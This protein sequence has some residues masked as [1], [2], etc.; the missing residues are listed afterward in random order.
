MMLRGRIIY[1]LY[2][3][4][5]FCSTFPKKIKI[6]SI[7]YVITMDKYFKVLKVILLSNKNRAKTKHSKTIIIVLNHGIQINIHFLCYEYVAYFYMKKKKY[8]I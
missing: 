4:I 2:Q 6:D 7:I 3:D 5:K 1:L 8:T